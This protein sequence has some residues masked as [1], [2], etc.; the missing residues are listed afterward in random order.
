MRPRRRGPSNFERST[1]G[2][3][4]DSAAMLFPPGPEG[5]P[6]RHVL[7]APSDRMAVHQVR[8]FTGTQRHPVQ[9][10]MDRAYGF[11]F[12]WVWATKD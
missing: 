1:T 2:F 8:W 9:E 7:D 12:S 4:A 6:L 3:G 11:G 10:L 5:R